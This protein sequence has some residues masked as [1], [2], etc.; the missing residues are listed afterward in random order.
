M[1]LK[2][3]SSKADISAN[4]AELMKAGH[5]QSQSIAIAYSEARKSHGIDSSESKERDKSDKDADLVAFI[6]YTNEDKILWL[7]RTKDGSWGFPG[8]HV[9]KGE[10]CIEGAIRESREEIQHTPET[11]VSLIWSEGK[12]RLYAC[13]DG[14]FSPILNDEHDGFMWAT[15]EEA[16]DP[17]F[18][19]IEESTEEIEAEIESSSEAMDRREYDTNGWFTVEDNPL[20]KIGVYQYSGAMID[21][22]GLDPEIDPSR[23]YNVFRSPEELGDIECIESFKLL[24]WI[25]NHVMLGSE[26]A[27]LMPAEQKGIQGVIGEQV[28]FDGET[29][30]GNIKVFS[31]AMAG[32]IKSGKK[33][34]SSGY[35][36]KYKKLAGIWKNQVYDFIQCAVRGN[37][38]ALVNSGRMGAEV[39]VLDQSE[40]NKETIMAEEAKKEDVKKEP[41]KAE[42]EDGESGEMSMEQAHEHLKTIMPI[43]AKM[44]K[45]LGGGGETKGNEAV[46]EDEEEDKKKGDEEKGS[47]M[48]AAEFAKVVTATIAEKESLY[49]SLSAHIG[50]FDHSE[51]DLDKMAKYGC[52]KLEIEAPKENRALFL[53]AYLSGK[54][55]PKVVSGMDS[56]VA[57]KGNFV[58]RHIQ[59]A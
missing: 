5:S 27:G 40:L 59:G 7:H 4:V 18:P 2:Q 42:G 19:K 25:D 55:A 41:V 8:G 9:E 51:M 14:S 56:S 21:P 38:L 26:E 37:H 48:D 17:M 44:Q 52:K 36:C 11:G 33:E 34:L 30:F 15:L 23:L 58:D 12:V 45:L 39:A 28:Y 31:E 54:G 46:G 3:G 20:S 49:K 57:K 43:I 24:P 47:G 29:L 16:P 13:D 53:K 10:S 1:P 6:C 35:R 32:L 50:T 22:L